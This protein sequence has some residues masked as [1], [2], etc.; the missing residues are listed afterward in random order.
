MKDQQIHTFHKGMVSDMGVTLP[1]EGTYINAEN[2]RITSVKGYLQHTG[3]SSSN[4]T[5]H[6]TNPMGIVVNVSG[7]EKILELYHHHEE[8]TL[9]S[10][11]GGQ[12]MEVTTWID[13][14]IFP[15]GFCTIR[16]TIVLF[17]VV[18]ND[19]YTDDGEEFNWDNIYSVSEE[20]GEAIVTSVIYKIDLNQPLDQ[21]ADASYEA[22]LIYANEGLNFH[23]KYPIEAV[24]RY[25]SPGIQ[26][27]YWTDNK[28]PVRTINIQ[29]PPENSLVNYT[30]PEELNLS[31]IV[32][33]EKLEVTSVSSGGQL[34]AGVYQ[35]FYRFKRSDGAIT[36]FTHPTNFVHVVN[37]S[38]YWKYIEDPENQSEYNGS[39][40]GEETNK[41]VKLS[42][43]VSAMLN[44]EGYSTYESIEF[45][46]IYR[47]TSQGSSDIKIIGET[48]IDDSIIE[49][50]HVTMDGVSISIEELTAFTQRLDKV[51]SIA[52]KDNR[53][54]FANIQNV[55]PGLTFDAV[56]KR[57]KRN[58]NVYYPYKSTNEVTTYGSFNNPYNDQD[59]W[60]QN[61]NNLYKYQNDVVTLGGT[62]EYIDF[63]FTKK[64]LLGNTQG[65]LEDSGESPPFVRSNI[66]DRDGYA[67]LK[68]PIIA[69]KYKGYQRDEVYRF[70]IVLYDKQGN[71]GFVNWIAD[72]RFPAHEDVTVDNNASLLKMYNFTLLQNNPSGSGLRLLYKTDETHLDLTDEAGFNESPTIPWTEETQS[73]YQGTGDAYWLSGAV[74][75]TGSPTLYT[76]IQNQTVNGVEAR[77]HVYSLGIEFSLKDLPGEIKDKV[78]GYSIV[79]IKRKEQDKSTLAVGALTNYFRYYDRKKNTYETSNWHLSMGDRLS[80]INSYP[81]DPDPT[82]GEF[83]SHQYGSIISQQCLYSISSPEFDFTDNYLTEINSP[84]EYSTGIH[85]DLSYYVRPIGGLHSRHKPHL[86]GDDSL[87]HAIVTNSH[88]I[89]K[90]NNIIKPT[91][92]INLIEEYLIHPIIISAKH[93]AGESFTTPELT[94]WLEMVFNYQQ[95]E[96]TG[97]DMG[98]FGGIINIITDT[99]TSDNDVTLYKTGIGSSSLFVMS[100][101]TSPL[102]NP[103]LNSNKFI[104]QSFEVY[105][106]S[107]AEAPTNGQYGNSY[108]KVL[109][110]IKKKNT[111]I[112]RYGGTDE[113]A[114]V[115]RNYIST[116]HYEKLPDNF[117]D[118]NKPPYT[119]VYG[120]DT[121]VTLYDISR[122]RKSSASLGDAAG[123]ADNLSTGGSDPAKARSIN[124]AFP[125]ETSINTTL[126][127]GYHFANKSDFS[128]TTPTP[129]DEYILPPVYSSENDIFSYSPIPTGYIQTDE[130]SA[131]VMFS[132]IKIDNSTSDGWRIVS[133]FNY[134]D[135]DGNLG[136]INKILVFNNIMYYFQ[137]TGFGMLNINPVST[138][139]DN[140]NNNVM[141]GT[142]NKVIQEFKTIS[143]NI[144]AVHN[145]HVIATKSGIYWFD[146]Y[147]NAIQYFNTQTGYIPL[148]ESKGFNVKG[149]VWK[150]SNFNV[151]EYPLTRGTLQAPR[152]TIDNHIIRLG[153]DARNNEV[154]FSFKNINTE[155]FP[156]PGIAG[157]TNST[158][159]SKTLVYNELLGA[160]TSFYTFAT[161]LFI[162]SNAS[163]FSIHEHG[164]YKHNT[165][166]PNS[167]SW[168]TEPQEVSI[169]FIANKHSIYT[170]VFDNLE[171][172]SYGN[173][174]GAEILTATQTPTGNFSIHGFNEITFSNSL[175]NKEVHLNEQ[176]NVMETYFPYGKIKESM[177]KVPIPRTSNG[178]RF[179]DTYLKI[180]LKG[181]KGVLHYVK[182]LFRISRR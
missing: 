59:E 65:L 39:T 140:N 151:E 22:S 173:N 86:T 110:A 7:N 114:I 138:V 166:N 152:V 44:E 49:F 41:R 12:W 129:F 31:P 46:A 112:S 111:H 8:T 10:T 175:G 80:Y 68:S 32:N 99:Y 178:A 83:I 4:P 15:V 123:P 160:F 30:S 70:G 21:F 147:S 72:I 97:T 16:N 172:Y 50:T 25:E 116:G 20:V 153:Y 108:D 130:H 106:T 11:Q 148:S 77:S 93:E 87:V 94:D 61:P 154:L 126:R 43:D 171:W 3:I 60:W 101:W 71:P 52:E 74:P 125:V 92:D 27:V 9:L 131:R 107:P 113:V 163:L 150:T 24:G 149:S 177:V 78:S 55:S 38:A 79:R 180:K 132:D 19:S 14:E 56:A 67:D 96:S 104:S 54:F 64:L 174:S 169:E 23:P 100:K 109:V 124:M 159:E 170:K 76:V 66:S 91:N 155:G 75:Q 69:E 162:Q 143:N 165:S 137:D 42:V 47:T 133:P 28:N 145:Q 95:N 128:Q 121:Y 73:E 164:L 134:E 34:P 17:G 157:L 146:A 5:G 89:Q 103:G 26:R 142:G 48:V 135:V 179:R 168:Y 1:Q 37:G 84:L 53:L 161:Y 35:Y 158:L 118:V 88:Y 62:G 182:T 119:T 167:C 117:G 18:I 40:P 98:S 57:Y 127:R 29:N 122:V 51:A 81:N 156:A 85:D 90:I 115:S 33:F 105:G 36:R 144:G 181:F 58:D 63:R 6:N 136:G 13:R 139:V 141:L 82:T 120:G 45:A 102:G 2:I 176:I